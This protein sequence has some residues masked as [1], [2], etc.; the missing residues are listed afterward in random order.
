[1]GKCKFRV[2]DICIFDRDNIRFQ[3]EYGTCK[4]VVI[5]TKHHLFSHNKYLVSDTENGNRFVCDESALCDSGCVML[6]FPADLPEINGHDLSAIDEAIKLLNT[7]YS[8]MCESMPAKTEADKEMDNRIIN[9]V[10]RMEA[11]KEKLKFCSEM[12]DI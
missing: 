9:T 10:N 2:G 12:R 5:H 3:S 7:L 4:V 8:V 6:R 1:M 11:L